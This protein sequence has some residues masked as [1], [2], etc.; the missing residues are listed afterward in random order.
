MT[1][2]SLRRV[3]MMVVLMCIVL[4]AAG[5]AQEKARLAVFPK[6]SQEILVYRGQESYLDFLIHGWGP[7]WN[8]YL[9]FRGEM[10]S[11]AESLHLKNAVTIRSSKTTL[12][13]DGTVTAVGEKR[14]EMDLSLSTDKD[15]DILLVTL[16]ITPKIA[17][18]EGTATAVTAAGEEQHKLPLGKSGFKGEVQTLRFT[19]K[20][21]KSVQISFDPA[22]RVASD[23]EARVVIAADAVAQANPAKLKVT[24]DFPEPMA[25][26]PGID[27]VPDSEDMST[28]FPFAAACDMSKASELDMSA[29]LDA[30]AGK[31]GR[32]T[33]R[34]DELMYNRKPIKLWGLN[35]CYNACSPEK[36]QADQRAAVY[37]RYGVNAVRLHKFADGTKSQGILDGK[38]Y[39]GFDPA[40]L[41]RLDYFV[42]ALKK[43][44]IFVKLSPNFG[45]KLWPDDVS[46]VSY[47]DEL[48]KEGNIVTPRNGTVFISRELQDL[49]I[50]QMVK[51]LKH[52][53][54][55][56]GLT[57]AEDPAVAV[58]EL[59]NEES[60]L[61]GGPQ[62]AMGSSPTLR[63][64]AGKLFFLWLKEKYGTKEKLFEA[65][66]EDSWNSFAYEK[67]AHDNWEEECVIPAGVH[68]WYT[69]PD[70]L[71]DSQASRKVR[72]MDAVE[73]MIG[74]QDEFYARYVK[75]I[76]DT[77]YEGE[78]LSSNW[79]AGRAYTHYAN[80]YSDAQVGLIDRHNYF[81]GGRGGIIRN[82]SMLAVPGGGSLSAGMQQVADRPFMLSE[83]I[84]V[85]PTE[86]GVEGP[87]I[88][89]AYGLGLQ[90][91]DVSYVFQNRDQ[92]RFL[93]QVG[94]RG[95]DVWQAMTPQILGV[96]P[97]V[98]RQVLRGDVKESEQL[99]VRSVHAPSLFDCKLGFEDK[100]EQAHDVKTFDSDKV[101]STSLATSRCVI[102]FT[103]APTETPVFD[104]APFRRGDALISS[105]KQLAW[106]AGAHKM[107]GHFTMDTPGTKAVVGFARGR[108]YT[109]GDVSI[110]SDSRFAAIYVTAQKRDE[111]IAT[112]GKILITAIARARNTDM[113]IFAD[114]VLLD[115]GKGPVLMEPVK[116]KIQLKR[117][118]TPTVRLLDHDGA[119]TDKTVPVQDGSFTIDGTRDKTCYYVVEYR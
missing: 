58:L 35:C 115:K 9:G 112:A 45:P 3:S 15:V 12:R 110:E 31:H 16:A 49:Q 41:D 8:P 114:T 56:T 80:L 43:K 95:H 84:H 61:F 111:T 55:H 81:G 21:G 33:R 78:I 83:W 37:A 69:D 117:A 85:A 77:G 4:A 92:G 54:P 75:A 82:A 68:P 90:G 89:G 100:V 36:E 76:R 71:A 57:Y 103:D 101:P 72:I 52:K 62:K 26:Y 24:I 87:A 25:F 116:A 39:V 30:P 105:T 53:N 70:Q 28:W 46:R 73:F 40:A 79:Q 18:A 91:W 32:I 6:A 60:A 63:K 14:L 104:L 88:I 67:L 38:S 65:W 97:A 7:G 102:D 106:Q 107:D 29:W 17:F 118:G 98:S 48:G 20:Q 1:S 19:D 34:D 86:W 119:A 96:F 51:M 94:G 93:E 22:V 23:D 74:L 99:A 47:A 66:G 59:L 13:V 113:K 27:R 50:E 44:G 108:S 64:R 2:Q 5:Y 11:E 42:A 10:T 109:L